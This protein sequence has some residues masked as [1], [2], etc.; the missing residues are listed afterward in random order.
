MVAHFIMR[1]Y[2]LNQTFRFVEGIL[3]HRKSL[4]IRFFFSD[5]QLHHAVRIMLLATILYYHCTRWPCFPRLPDTTVPRRRL[6]PT[7]GRHSLHYLISVCPKGFESGSGFLNEAWS[8]SRFLNEVGSGFGFLKTRSDHR[9]LKYILTK[10]IIN[11]I[12]NY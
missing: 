12:L 1:T 10:E 6:Y 11:T 7:S 3:V 4:Q 8:G 2:G 5:I 9:D